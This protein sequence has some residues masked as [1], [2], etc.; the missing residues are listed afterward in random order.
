MV[1]VDPFA[2][3][4]AA[5][6]EGLESLLVGGNAV[7]LY[8]YR[9]TT[10]DVDLLIREE[11]CVRW[12]EF[13]ERHGFRVYHRAANFARLHFAADPR[14][15][16]PVDLMLA[17][18]QTFRKLQSDSRRQLVTTVELAV[19]SAL[20][21]IAM[22]LHALKSEARMQRSPDFEDVI[23]LIKTAKIEICGADFREVVER[24]ASEPIRS[25]IEKL[26]E[27]SEGGAA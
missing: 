8:A 15:S 27:S 4:A 6:A 9:R 22:K 2:L 5:E 13:F 19:P 10:F 3:A 14:K 11:E 21:L 16:L 7:N 24:Y 20:H 1:E 17:D 25:R 18:E 12:I 23:H 26:F